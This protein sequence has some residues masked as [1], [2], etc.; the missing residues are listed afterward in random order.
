[1][2]FTEIFLFVLGAIVGSF[3][4]VCI[5]R[6]PRTESVVKPRSHCVSCNKMIPWYDNIPFISYLLLGA[7][8]RFCKQKISF[9]YFIVE[10]ITACFF[11]LLYRV[12][13]LGFEYINYLV[14]IC[15]LIIATFV[16]LDFRIIPDEVSV[17]GIVVG[18]VLSLI[19]SF[20]L[21]GKVQIL[22]L[23][24]IDSFLGVLIG[25]GLIYLTGLFGNLLFF[26][27]MKKESIDG[28]TESMGG[29]DVK[30]LAMIGAFIGWK[31]S[32]LTF[33]IAPF[34]GSVAGVYILLRKGKHT[35]AYGPAIALAAV[36]CIFYGKVI[37]RMLFGIDI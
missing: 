29:G 30:L 5:Y 24:I 17:G 20:K 18:L 9:R 6:M 35:L 33:F 23:P 28:E 32:I 12:F 15:G 19:E 37:V 3:L 7:K 34:L 25:G 14:L 16:D 4:N 21:F 1:M 22:E 27:L 10:F 26:K 2:I 36:I 8:C 13:G 31:L 11:I